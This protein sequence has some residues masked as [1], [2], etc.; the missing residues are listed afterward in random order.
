[1]SDNIFRFPNKGLE[2]EVDLEDDEWNEQVSEA[3]FTILKMNVEGIVNTSDVEWVHIMD[4]A[5][6]VGIGAGLAAGYTIE[7]MQE[8]ISASDRG[9]DYDA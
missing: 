6:N 9:Y 8:V 4:A 5:L 3:V 7:E 2:V 1:M